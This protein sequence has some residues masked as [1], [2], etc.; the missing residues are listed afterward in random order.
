MKT[1]PSIFAAE[2]DPM[3]DEQDEFRARVLSAGGAL[4]RMRYEGV[5]HSFFGLDHL[6]PTARRA[7]PEVCAA[8]ARDLEMQDSAALGEAS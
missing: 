6:S 8:V 2:Y 4:E 1:V 3:C 5:G 7:Q